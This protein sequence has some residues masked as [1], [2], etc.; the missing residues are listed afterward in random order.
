MQD[1]YK[2]CF[3]NKIDENENLIGMAEERLLCPSKHTIDFKISLNEL[4]FRRKKTEK[5]CK[6]LAGF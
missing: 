1:K 2:S 3:E 5:N 6:K 4:H